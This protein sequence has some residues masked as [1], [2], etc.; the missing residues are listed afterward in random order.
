MDA[1][2]YLWVDDIRFPRDGFNATH[3]VRTALEAIALLATGRV[4]R[5]SLDHD[6]NVTPDARGQT[7]PHIP[8]TGL[9]IVFWMQ[10]TGW[11]PSGGV[12]VH[13][14]NPL[15]APLMRQMIRQHYAAQRAA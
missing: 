4:V 10:A 8:Q 14:A 15:A 11:W 7:L 9:E 5:A 3:C 12:D 1:P 13:S 2:V 6:L